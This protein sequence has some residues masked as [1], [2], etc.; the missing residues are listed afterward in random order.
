MKLQITENKE[1]VFF[2]KKNCPGVSSEKKIARVSV[3]TLK[4]RPSKIIHV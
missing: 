3:V 2:G 4:R 1:N